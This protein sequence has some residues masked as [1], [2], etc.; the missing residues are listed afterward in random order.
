[1]V[2]YYTHT[3]A[4]T[5]VCVCD[6]IYVY[7]NATVLQQYRTFSS[8]CRKLILFHRVDA[9]KKQHFWA[10]HFLFRFCHDVGEWNRER[11]H[12]LLLLFTFFFVFSSTPFAYN[13][14]TPPHFAYSFYKLILTF[15]TLLSHTNLYS[16][17]L[18]FSF[19]SISI[20]SL[21]PLL[22]SFQLRSHHSFHPL[23][24]SL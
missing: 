1:M 20:V 3:Q 21:L 4:H 14:K 16:L 22:L 18:P 8:L 6:C 13:L 23:P 12:G 19:P 11:V 10:P 24:L 17:Y 7:T 5:C 2:I 9:P 15:R